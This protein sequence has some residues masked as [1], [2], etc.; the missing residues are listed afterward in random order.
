MFRFADFQIYS[1]ALFIIFI[2]I[3]YYIFKYKSSKELIE[4]SYSKR[5][6]KYYFGQINL[7]A[8]GLIHYVFTFL[9]LL[10]LAIGLFRPQYG[11]QKLELNAEGVELV[12]VVDVSQSMAAEDVKPQRLKL[13]QIQLKN[14]T[15]ILEGNRMGLVAFA[16][17]VGVI[18][19]LTQDIGAINLFIESLDFDVFTEQGT[20]IG[21]ALQEAKAL[22]ERGQGSNTKSRTKV[23]VLITDGE[24][25]S[26][27]ALNAVKQLRGN[28]IRTFVIGV[29]TVY[30]G[31]IPVKD[32]YGQTTEYLK[33]R[34]GSN[35]VTKPNFDFLKELSKEGGGGFYK[36]DFGSVANNAIA[37]DFNS[38][39]KSKF[40]SQSFEVKGEYFQLFLSLGILCLLLSLLWPKN[41]MAQTIKPLVE[42]ED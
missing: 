29:G 38:L 31:K 5:F 2:L 13:A 25:H 35:I 17:Q 27:E 9:G 37:K 20:N 7:Q 10:L 22:L 34:S 8:F 32:T 42:L 28:D 21:F 23:V 19:P 4:I 1:F 26:G 15:Q 18:S 14:L 39:Q 6:I 40:E 41:Q 11:S 12:F 33:D 24:D 16:G 30:G 36:L 3:I